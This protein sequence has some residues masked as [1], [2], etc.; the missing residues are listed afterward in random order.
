MNLILEDVSA[1]LY[2]RLERR[3]E[4]KHRSLNAEVLD[5]LTQVLNPKP[6]NVEELLAEVRRLRESVPVP[7]ITDLFLREAK[8]WGRH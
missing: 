7:L 8:D 2:R 1:E 6:V 3:A 5:I 4:E